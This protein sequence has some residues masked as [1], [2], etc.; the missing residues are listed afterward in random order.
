M[1]YIMIDCMRTYNIPY[2]IILHIF[3][4]TYTP[5]SPKLLNDIQNYY[6]T[7]NY[8]MNEYNKMWMEENI[9]LDFPNQAYIINDFANYMFATQSY[10]NSFY[11]IFYRHY[12]INNKMEA[13][14]YMR[15]LD[16][17]PLDTQINI[18]WGLLQP[19]ERDEFVEELRKPD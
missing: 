15:W 9:D 18:Y 16:T 3:S 5:Q 12:M 1:L 17:I 8:L 11:H 6:I 14:R 13:V 2:T 4:Y 10:S 7:K 19:Y